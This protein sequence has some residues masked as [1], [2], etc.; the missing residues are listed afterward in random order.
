MWINF[1]YFYFY[2]FLDKFYFSGKPTNLICELFLPTHLHM[3]NARPNW[4][5]NMSHS[6]Q[7]GLLTLRHGS[8]TISWK[9]LLMHSMFYL[10]QAIDSVLPYIFFIKLCTYQA[11]SD[12]LSSMALQKRSKDVAQKILL[13]EAVLRRSTRVRAQPRDS[14]AMAFLRYVNKWKEN[15]HTKWSHIRDYVMNWQYLLLCHTPQAICGWCRLSQ[16]IR[17]Y[18]DLSS[19]IFLIWPL[20]LI[21]GRFFSGLNTEAKESGA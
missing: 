11:D 10:K 16:G 12:V 3:Q 6:H 21:K 18:F 1:I 7:I 14:S 2:S 19:H 17:A 9:H 5:F 8:A 4:S 20:Y 15:W 13:E